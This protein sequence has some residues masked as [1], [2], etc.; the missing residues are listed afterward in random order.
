MAP[1]MR[2]VFAPNPA[3]APSAVRIYDEIERA[4]RLANEADASGNKPL[5]QQLR[6]RATFL[7]EQSKGQEEVIGYDDNNRPIIRRGKGVG[8][9]PTVATASRAQQKLQKYENATEIINRLQQGLKAGHVGLA[10]L[11]GEYLWD[12]GLVQLANLM[13][14]QTAAA[15]PERVNSRA[16]LIMLR[17]SLM[18]EISDDTRFSQP[19]R[20]EIT[21]SLPSSGAFESLSNAQDKLKTV[22]DIITQRS[23]VYAKSIQQTPPLFSLDVEEIKDLFKQGK[24]DRKTALEAL[25]R[26][27]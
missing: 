25:T 23:K 22:R 13:G 10:G 18:K 9:Q 8:N 19:D 1:G 14:D 11:A 16:G 24:I 7:R 12:R 27:H 6:D 5:A 20:E 21:K 3:T 4:E 26:F 15:N 2:P 17:E